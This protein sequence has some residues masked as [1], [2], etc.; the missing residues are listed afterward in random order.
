MS[1]STRALSDGD[2]SNFSALRQLPSTTDALSASMS[3][4]DTDRFISARRAR[5]PLSVARALSNISL[6][7]ADTLAGN[8]KSGFAY[9]SDGFAAK[10]AK[11]EAITVRSID[12]RRSIYKNID[13]MSDSRTSGMCLRVHCSVIP[14]APAACCVDMY[15]VGMAIQCQSLLC[16][17]FIRECC[18]ITSRVKRRSDCVSRYICAGV[19]IPL[20]FA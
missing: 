9:G 6:A 14:L 4:R 7:L 15:V 2:D 5:G 13:L 8:A 12:I 16:F 3:V 18:F 1:R 17:C 19:S 10:A 11:T 20:N